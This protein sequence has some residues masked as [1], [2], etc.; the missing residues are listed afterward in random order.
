MAL[1]SQPLAGETTALL[2]GT[3][4]RSLKNDSSFGSFGLWL[5]YAVAALAG[6]AVVAMAGTMLWGTHGWDPQSDTDGTRLNSTS[7]GRFIHITDLHIDPNYLPGST[8]YSQCHRLPP[9]STRVTDKDGHRETGRFGISQAKCDTPVALINATSEYLRQE[10][11]DQVD[12]VVWTGDSG[13]HDNDAEIPRTFD[14][15]IEQNRVAARAMRRAFGHTTVVPN[16]GN[17]DISPHNEL[18]EPGHKRA[19]K[20]FRLLADAW[21]DLVPEDQ[22]ATFLYGGYFARDLVDYDQA[23]NGEKQGLTALSLN[24]IYWYRANAKVG[25]CR[26]EDSPGLAQ[27]AWIRY[28]IRRAR[29]RNR[30]LILLGHVVPNRDNYRPTCYHGYARTVTQMIPSP[31]DNEGELP[32]VH[33]Q[34][35]GH[36]NVDV[37]SFVGHEVEWLS[38]TDPLA[39]NNKRS[40]ASDGRLWWEKQVDEE[41]GRF[42]RM[43]RDIWTA[44]APDALPRLL[45]SERD[46]KLMPDDPPVAFKHTRKGLFPF[47]NSLINQ[48]Q[49]SLPGNFVESLLK[50]FER[51]LVQSPRQPR[52]GI[53]TISPS[54]I[55]RYV[56]AFRV[57][58]YKR[59]SSSARTRWRRHLPLG[60]LLDYDVYW[61]NLPE[62]NKMKHVDIKGFFQRLYRFSAVYRIEDLS[63]DSYLQWAR[64]LLEN[65]ALRKKFRALT[66]LNT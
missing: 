51:V 42:G 66:Y 16:I 41:T 47:A 2:H 58:Y 49:L 1:N 38:S 4:H 30:D 20:T 19:R 65:K 29:D 26:A 60:T 55:P 61:A 63:V 62:I 17:N 35:F 6:T 56:P 7:V 48:T 36:S 44:K 32:R 22:L 9:H 53:T 34:L 5:V 13:R 27:L 31:D 59:R 28:Q 25:G 50:E 10:W 37:W 12:F 40:N 8:T 14:E 52:L 57:F 64:K 54:I 23:H 15:I 11:A 18:A 43:I 46:W 45:H 24:T 39:T 33:A 3:P 21:A